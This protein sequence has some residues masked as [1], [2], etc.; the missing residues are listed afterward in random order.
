MRTERGRRRPLPPAEQPVPR[1]EQ[2]LEQD[3]PT[4]I[5]N[6]AAPR[7]HCPRSEG[8]IGLRLREGVVHGPVIRDHGPLHSQVG[9]RFE[10]RPGPAKPRDQPGHGDGRI[11]P[12]QVEGR[13]HE[14]LKAQ[15]EVPQVGERGRQ[16]RRHWGSGPGVLRAVVIPAA[17]CRGRPLPAFG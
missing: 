17:V 15:G 12:A 3:R 2:L 10:H 9:A 13:Y 16:L 1:V 8:R 5:S 14:V 4:P 11:P 6:G 7:S